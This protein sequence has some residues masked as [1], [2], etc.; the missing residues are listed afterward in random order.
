MSEIKRGDT[1]D[2][3]MDIPKDVAFIIDELYSHGYEAYAVGGCVRDSILGREPGDWDITTSA[4]PHEVKAIFR[5]TVDTGIQHGTVTVMLGKTGY[6]VT[7]Y[8]VDGV[9]E[10]SRHPKQ[11]SFTA[12]LEED[13]KRRDFTINAMAYNHRTGLVDIFDGIGD[14]GRKVIR[15][16]GDA[17]ERFDEDALRMLR[18]VRFSAQLGFEIEKNTAAA[19]RAKADSLKKISAERI[20][21][22]LVKLLVSDNPDYIHKAYELGI[23]K[24]ILPEYDAITGVAQNT[25]NHIYTV[26]V[27]TLKALKSIEPDPVLRWTMLLHDFGK[28]AV[29]R[30]KPDGR[31]IFYRHPE[32][33]ARMAAQILKRLK[34]DN[35]TLDHVVRLVKWHGLKYF[36]EETDLR[37]A[38]NRVGRDIFDDFLKVQ[39][40]DVK[41][42]SPAVVAGKLALLAEKEKIYHKIIEE[43]QCFEIRSLAVNGRDLICAGIAPGPLLGAVLERLLEMVIEDQSLNEKE[44]LLALAVQVKDDDTIFEE[45]EAFF[46]H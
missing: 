2:M 1:M 36:A 10:D 31:D 32:V 18:A 33:S 11:V 39:T 7:T 5:R 46:R 43:N 8:R 30:T 9:Y 16:V 35:Y 22:E 38:L 26:D 42:K 44:K 37:K 28:P 25:P 21:A 40:A 29:K 20:Q 45:K 27:H 4:K 12:S 14:I 15:C 13:L 6:E 3:K 34:F 41:A 17:S 19:V 24:V 23:T